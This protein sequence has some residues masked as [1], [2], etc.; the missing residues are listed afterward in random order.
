MPTALV[1]G[2]NRGLG[3]ELARQYAREG[4]RVLGTVRTTAHAA[5]LRVYGAEIYELDVR[6]SAE[7]A[8]LASM[9][10]G[11][12][13]DVLIA[14]AGIYEG[15]ECPLEAIT[16]D[17]WLDTFRTNTIGPVLLARHFR[18][19]V[20]KSDQR[21]MVAI[22]SRL[23]S[24]SAN[25]ERGHYA[26]RTSKAA[27][28]AAWRALS[29]DQPGII[30]VLLAPGWVRTDMGGPDAPL[31]PEESVKYLREIIAGLGPENT[32]HWYDVQGRHVPW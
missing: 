17:K 26:Y 6:S 14:N 2:A 16:E 25:G 30:T 28:N 19:H 5:S 23:G 18:E 31:L 20:A 15:M 13:I 24:I 22:T 1:T 29:L 27:L 10:R 8:G 4:W 3:L 9:L 32:G 11:T 21:K 7:I 12:A